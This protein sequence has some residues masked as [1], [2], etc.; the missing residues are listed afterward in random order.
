[1]DSLYSG[2]TVGSHVPRY[3]DNNALPSTS[4]S[5]LGRSHPAQIREVMLLDAPFYSCRYHY[6]GADRLG[7]TQGF[8][9]TH[10]AP[11]LGLYE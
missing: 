7:Y 4:N 6:V 3:I 10:K 5:R 1:L 9:S 2:G 8:G 11:M